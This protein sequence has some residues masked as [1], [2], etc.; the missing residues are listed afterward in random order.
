MTCEDYNE[1][2]TVENGLKI[3]L[4]QD[5]VA[6]VDSCEQN[7]QLSGSTQDE[8]SFDRTTNSERLCSMIFV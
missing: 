5:K 4:A 3:I 6:M 1:I 7:N 2:K 8:K